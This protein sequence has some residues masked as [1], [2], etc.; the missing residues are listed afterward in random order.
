[1]LTEQWVK[2]TRSGASGDCVEARLLEGVVEVRDSKDPNGPA[3]KFAPSEW[4]A[5]Q[6]G[7][8]DGEFAIPS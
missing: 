2:S 3:L 1:M 5:F 8:A 4:N 7:M 6:G